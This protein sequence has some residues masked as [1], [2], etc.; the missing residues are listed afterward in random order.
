MPFWKA[1][2]ITLIKAGMKAAPAFILPKLVRAIPQLHVGLPAGCKFRI[3]YYLGEVKVDIDT[4]YVIERAML[5]GRYDPQTVSIIRR[6]VKPGNIC[7]D[8]GANVGAI[9]FAIAQQCGPSGKVFAFEPGGLT[10]ER[11]QANLALNPGY[12][13]AITP[14]R[15]GL[16]DK[17]GIL[18]WNEHAENRGNANLSTEPQ[19]GATEVPV[20]TLDKWTA[21]AALTRLD[22]VKIDVESMEYEVILGGRE[23]WGRFLPTLYYETLPAFE[24]FRGKPVFKLIEDILKPL[25][26]VF[27]KMDGDNRLRATTYPDLSANTLA[28]PPSRRQ[29]LDA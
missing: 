7:L 22:F 26:Y 21:Q 20:T 6:M 12:A 28:V 16:S 19:P 13:K 10:Y 3:D 24:A 5:S 1:K 18:Y 29:L 4:T 9:A 17:D 25:G 27:Y 8:V 15:L 14:L 11:F 23:T 2:A